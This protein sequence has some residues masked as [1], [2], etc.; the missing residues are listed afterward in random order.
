MLIRGFILSTFLLIYLPSHTS[1]QNFKA[2]LIGGFTISQ[3]EGDKLTGYNKA[4]FVVGGATSFSMN[5]RWS[6]QQEIVYSQR[7]SR[8]S[9][10][11]FFADDFTTLRLDYIDVLLLP[12]YHINDRWRVLAGFGYG[13]FL[14]AKSDIQ[15]KVSFTHDLFATAGAQYHLGHKWWGSLRLQFSMVDVIVTRGALNN[16]INFMLRYQL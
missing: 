13:V 16:S 5:D 10:E 4:G 15:T 2:Y 3:I 8:A 14:N 6:L 7:G 11:E 9:E 12:M 1:A